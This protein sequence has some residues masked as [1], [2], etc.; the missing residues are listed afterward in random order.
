M[1]L[2]KTVN[3]EFIMIISSRKYA[4][5]VMSGSALMGISIFLPWNRIIITIYGYNYIVG[6]FAYFKSSILM[7][8]Y[9]IV[10]INIFISGIIKAKDMV[11]SPWYVYVLQGVASVGIIAY[12][13]IGLDLC[14]GIGPIVAILGSIIVCV[15]G[16]LEYRSIQVR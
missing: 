8:L 14:N 2:G 10:A 16:L 1:L 12:M 4:L 11:S 3:K 13:C 9:L 7:L 5:I 6:T 15:G